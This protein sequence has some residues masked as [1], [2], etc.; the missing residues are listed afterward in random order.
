M[1]RNDRIVLSALAIAAITIVI[2]AVTPPLSEKDYVTLAVAV[3]STFVAAFAGTWGAQI[4]AERTSMRR[5]ILDELRA[6]NIALAM[7]F[8]IANTYLSAKKI[9]TREMKEQYDQQREIYFARE[10][11][12]ARGEL[13]TPETLGYPTNLKTLIP[14]V[15]PIDDL[16]NILLEKISG[17]RAHLLLMPLVQ[18]IGFLTKAIE[19]RNEWIDRARPNLVA[20]NF[21]PELLAK[22][23]GGPGEYGGVDKSYAGFITAMSEQTD[24]CIG[25]GLAMIDALKRHGDM[26]RARYGTGAPE[27]SKPDFSPAEAQGLVPDLSLYQN[28]GH[29]PST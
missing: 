18:S 19:A 2:I 12:R 13:P 20:N 10:A 15:S 28:W 21:G 16:K 22:Y 17:M 23:F 7:T 27:I 24:M 8:V 11:A 26:L 3:V 6:I 25:F 1:D 14:P 4:V 29:K 5:A 9:H